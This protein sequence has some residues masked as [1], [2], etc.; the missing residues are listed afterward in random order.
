MHRVGLRGERRGK[1]QGMEKEE[2][3][4]KEKEKCPKIM[5]SEG[6]IVKMRK[7]VTIKNIMWETQIEPTLES[8]PVWYGLQAVHINWG[9]T[10]FGPQ[11][12][13]RLLC[14]S[15]YL[16]EEVLVLSHHHTGIRYCTHSDILQQIDIIQL[17]VKGYE[18][19]SSPGG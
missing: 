18:S 11:D 19:T 10:L 14:T 3:K 7:I 5:S 16:H 17:M 13:W 15:E 12:I 4:E 6:K 1:K 2:K 8:V 9:S